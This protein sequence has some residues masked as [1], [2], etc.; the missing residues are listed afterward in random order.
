[1][2]SLTRIFFPFVW[3]SRRQLFLSFFF[4]LLVALLW[5]ATLSVS[6]PV[7]KVLLQGETLAEHIQKQIA[8]CEER[9]AKSKWELKEYEEA[10]LVA[11][12][13]DL[14]SLDRKKSRSDDKMAKAQQKLAI[15]RWVE[16]NVVICDP[17]H[18]CTHSGTPPGC[19]LS[20]STYP[21]GGR[22][23]TTPA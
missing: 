21:G 10:V 19:Y 20:F 14:P 22:V 13:Y 2:N 17:D 11:Q 23:A 18:C 5:G 8:A 12:K 16:V 15:L 1:M 3:P 9:V 4:A 7:V 6:Y